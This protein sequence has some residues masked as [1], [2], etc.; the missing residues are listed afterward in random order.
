MVQCSTSRCRSWISSG[1]R[2]SI[3]DDGIGINRG[4]SATTGSPA[5]DISRGGSLLQRISSLDGRW[6]C[7]LRLPSCCRTN[8]RSKNNS[9]RASPTTP[10]FNQADKCDSNLRATRQ[11]ELTEVF[12]AHVVSAWLGNSER[13]AAQHYLQVLDSHFEKA[14]RI[15]ARTTPSSDAFETHRATEFAKPSN[16]RGG[17]FE[18]HAQRDSNPRPTD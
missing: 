11:T 10:P 16:I 14:A 1:V 17:A 7:L 15:P 4:F 8:H 3:R 2:L 12:P 18:R 6:R 13:I 9:H 5:E